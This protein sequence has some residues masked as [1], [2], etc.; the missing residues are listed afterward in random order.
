MCSYGVCFNGGHCREGSTQLCDCLAGFN[1]P[2]CQYDVNECEETN[3]GCEA[4]C[5][6]TIG[7]FYC[8]CPPGQKLNEEGKTCQG[9]WIFFLMLIEAMAYLTSA[10]NYPQNYYR[11]ICYR[12]HCYHGYNGHRHSPP[13]ADID[14]CQVHNGGCQHRCV[15]TR[16]SYRCECHPGS[17]MHVDGRTCI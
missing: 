8:R 14:E 7:S 9:Q 5:S 16:G 2:S 6:N 15:N 13:A 17:R 4:L 1:G 3:G 12:P 10:A 11:R